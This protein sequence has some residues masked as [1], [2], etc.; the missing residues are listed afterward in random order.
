MKIHEITGTVLVPWDFSEMSSKALK[1]AVSMVDSVDQI[2]VVHVTLMPSAY[3]YGVVWDTVSNDT[4]VTRVN[5][6]FRKYI[7]GDE[8]L[9]DINFVTL[10]GEPGRRI[11]DYAEEIKAGLIVMPSH[12]RSGISHLL[13]GSVAERV[14]RGAPC[15]ILV[16]RDTKADG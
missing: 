15:P 6:E 9:A 3:E 10:F 5:E 2:R 7:A 4:V 16:L 8:A 12:G 1:S 14:V 11:C 13:L